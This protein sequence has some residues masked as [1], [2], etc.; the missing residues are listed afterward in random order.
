MKKIYIYVIS[1]LLLLSACFPTR[2]PSSPPAEAVA[3]F[4]AYVKAGEYTGAN[5]LVLGELPLKLYEIEEGHQ[6][7]FKNLSYE[8]I[9][10]E[11]NG[12]QA[13]VSLT[14][15]NLDF[16]AVMEEVFNEAFFNWIFMDIT[17]QELEDKMDAL[18][19]ERMGADTVPLISQQVTV[20]L[21]IYNDQWKI[22]AD[23]TFA[24]A[25]SGGLISVTEYAEQW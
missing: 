19:I 6:L 16:A 13:T 24:D 11:I 25:V 23:P 4:L 3:T 15:S 20:T 18:L 1:T 7:I 8:D 21:E 2:G 22:I 5:N 12:N 9:T 17:D 10:E 14:I